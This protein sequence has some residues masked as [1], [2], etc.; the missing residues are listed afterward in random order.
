MSIVPVVKCTGIARSIAF[1]TGVLDFELQGVWPEAADPAYAFL[2]RQGREMHLS[3]HAGD[4]VVGQHLIVRVE[5]V[6]AVAAAVFA[7]GH[8]ASAKPDSPIHQ[9]PTDQTWGTRDFAVDD[10]DGN[11]VVFV[12]R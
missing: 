5:D 4:G 1:Y 12:Q 8:D 11:T 7:R 9:G 6:D 2:T 3:S 10:P